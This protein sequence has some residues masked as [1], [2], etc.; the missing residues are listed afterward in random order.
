MHTK[1]STFIFENSKDVIKIKNTNI[2]YCGIKKI[3]DRDFAYG[4]V[5]EPHNT[6]E[7]SLEYLHD[8]IN[9]T[10]K[11]YKSIITELNTY[12]KY[13]KIIVTN[14][15]TTIKYN[16]ED[17]SFLIKYYKAW[18]NNDSTLWQDVFDDKQ[19]FKS[20][21]KRL[22]E[23]YKDIQSEIKIA[24][25]KKTIDKGLEYLKSKNINFV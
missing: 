1:F 9:D 20:E 22:Y 6:F 18:Q 13:K 19:D 5:A 14:F 2:F 4:Y 8:D 21:Y 17:I 25:T 24:S 16:L 23:L 7:I 11:F 3:D 15:D 12:K 10:D